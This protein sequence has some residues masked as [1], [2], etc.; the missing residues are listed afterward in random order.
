MLSLCVSILKAFFL[1]SNFLSE[2]SSSILTRGR[3]LILI[4]T[5]KSLWLLPLFFFLS[6]L[7][8]LAIT[9]VCVC[10]SVQWEIKK[11]SVEVT[12]QWSD[13]S[14][15]HW[16]ISC[17][18][19]HYLRTWTRFACHCL[20]TCVSA[21]VDRLCLALRA[22]GLLFWVPLDFPLVTGPVFGWKPCRAPCWRVKCSCTSPWG[23]K[24]D[25]QRRCFSS[26]F[27]SFNV[28]FCLHRRSLFS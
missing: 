17:V 4:F 15:C 13:V 22:H 18:A 20:S 28:S 26:S 27:F 2:H 19:Q 25:K 10:M 7:I 5:V 1:G 16:H 12:G 11:K 21:E 14:L 3:I 9:V 23:L 24:T 8:T 6:S